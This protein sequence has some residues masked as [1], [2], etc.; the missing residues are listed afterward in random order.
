MKRSFR[1]AIAGAILL[2]GFAMFAIL[3][4][5]RHTPLPSNPPKPFQ[6][7]ETITARKGDLAVTIAAQGVV[8]PVTVTRAA[9]E[10]DGL[11]VAV[12]PL[13]EAGGVFQKGDV[14]LEIDPS[15]YEAAIAQAKSTL[16]DAKLALAE[17]EMRAR[18]AERDWNRL[19]TPGQTP[20]D[21]V[22]RL[23]QLEAAKARVEAATAALARAEKELE[24]TKL[25]APY[26]GRVRAKL[27]DLG[28]RVGRGEPLAEFYATDRFEVRLPVPRQD[29]AFLEIDG[30]EIELREPGGR[31]RTWRATLH[32][33]EGEIRRDD[34][35]IVV[36]A[37][38]DG[39]S[40]DAPLPG[41]FVETGLPG[42]IVPGIV[43]V[44]RR[45]FATSDR[46]MVVGDGHTVT[47]RPVE[48][49]RT[50]RDEVLVSSGIED[51]EQLCVTALAAVI[52]GM[53]VKV[54][55]R[56]GVP[57]ADPPDAP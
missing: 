56:D 20:T 12:S 21:L 9:A 38:L 32:R 44:P 37:R 42:R 26:E 43:R 48:I 4:G 3:A 6:E 36:V 10:V 25:R 22:R 55:S 39:A 19:A 50:E 16:S 47:T 27:A 35:T 41:Q 53:E 23:P 14:L 34:R 52:E 30:R 2:A 31:G 5:L 49:L 18:Q 40:P 7:V 51:G 29:A 57:V 28:S 46:V 54:V 13:L 33:T 24:R 17:E 11:V 45:A 8:E 1:L 15:D